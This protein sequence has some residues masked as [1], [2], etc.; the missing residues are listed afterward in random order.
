MAKRTDQSK[1]YTVAE[2]GCWL[3]NCASSDKDGY[4]LFSVN[5]KFRR[6]HR[7]F[8]EMHNGEIPKGM[9]VCHRCD[10]PR[11]CNPEHLFLGTHQDNVDDMVRKGRHIVADSRRGKHGK[12]ARGSSCGSSKLTELSV[13]HIRIALAMGA[14]RQAVADAYGVTYPNILAIETRKTWRDI[15]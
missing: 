5:G 12:Q 13:T 7:F 10:T 14:S 11:C 9:F 6:A 4:V 3:H 8:W 1:N 2:N 15:P